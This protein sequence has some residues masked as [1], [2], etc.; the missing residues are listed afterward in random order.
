[1]TAAR[2]DGT[3]VSAIL[4]EVEMQLADNQRRFFDLAMLIYGKDE[5]AAM[6]VLKPIA[7]ANSEALRVITLTRAKQFAL[8]EDVQ[9]ER[10]K[11]L[12]G[13]QA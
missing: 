13:R 9:L 2:T 8:A 4:A 6:E 1:M 11:Q 10:R 3:R 5:K 7:D 12:K